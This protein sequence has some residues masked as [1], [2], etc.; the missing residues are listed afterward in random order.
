MIEVVGNTYRLTLTGASFHAHLEG[1]MA[2]GRLF[3]K[4]KRL[5]V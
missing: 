5:Y 1:L 2:N 3:N 4:V